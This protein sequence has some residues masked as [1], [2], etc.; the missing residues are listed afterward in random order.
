M[1]TMVLENLCLSS[2]NNEELVYCLKVRH[3][4]ISFG[5][6]NVEWKLKLAFY[7]IAHTGVELCS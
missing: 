4:Y 2:S 6:F 1:I 3:L 7:K 5:N